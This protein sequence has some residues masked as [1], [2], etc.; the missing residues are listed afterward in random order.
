MKSILIIG[1]GVFGHHLAHQFLENGQ[2]VMLID[3]DERAVEDMVTCGASIRI[4]DCTN[5]EVLKNVGI[6]NFDMVFVCMGEDFQNSLEVTYLCHELQAQYV[7]SVATREVQAKF[8]LRNGA[9]EVVYPEKDIAEKCAQ[10]Y[11]VNHVFDYIELTDG[12][13]IF[14]IPPVREWIG[15]MIKESNIAAKHHITILGIK[16][17]EKHTQIMPG[18]DYTIKADEHLLVLAKA[19]T[20]KQLMAKI[21]DK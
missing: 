8:L 5:P 3:K 21:K 14:E 20:I 7:V 2:D 19:E 13:A 16:K 17:S 11:S 15:K 18:A 10:K 12:Y 9:D 1:L 6:R 4:G